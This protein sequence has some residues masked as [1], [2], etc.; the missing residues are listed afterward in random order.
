M[1]AQCS[2]MV[3]PGTGNTRGTELCKRLFGFAQYLMAYHIIPLFLI[4]ANAGYRLLQQVIFL[5]H[6]HY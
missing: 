4:F 1:F 2:F 6:L 5:Q 3:L